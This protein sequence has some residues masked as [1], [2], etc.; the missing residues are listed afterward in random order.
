ME[1]RAL[2]M[3][4]DEPNE[5][6]IVELPARPDY[7]ELAAVLRP[8]LDT[9]TF[10]HVTVLSDFEGGLDFRPSDMFVDEMGHP[11]GLPLNGAATAIYRRNALLHQ[12]VSDP[13]SL[14]WIAGPAI[15]FER[16]VWT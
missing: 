13:E 2:L 3:R 1:F 11:K 14:P 15:L 7:H 6:R 12:G 5:R 16:I 4:P 10:E 8:L 9:Q